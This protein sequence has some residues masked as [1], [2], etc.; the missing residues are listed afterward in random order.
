MSAKY[1]LLRRLNELVPDAPLLT[2]LEL[3]E[4]GDDRELG[5]V[6]RLW[7]AWARSLRSESVGRP[8]YVGPAYMHRVQTMDGEDIVNT[9]HELGA[10]TGLQWWSWHE[11]SLREQ[12]G[13]IQPLGGDAPIERYLSHAHTLW[14]AARREPDENKVAAIEREMRQAVPL[15]SHSVSRLTWMMCEPCLP[16]QDPHLLRQTVDRVVQLMSVGDR[17]F[18]RTFRPYDLESL[19]RMCV[20]CSDEV[21]NTHLSAIVAQLNA[22]FGT[23]GG[24][25]KNKGARPLLRWA[26]SPRADQVTA[27]RFVQQQYDEAS[28][29]SMDQDLSPERRRVL[30]DLA[31]YEAAMGNLD[32]L[33]WMVRQL[34]TTH[35][36]NL[37]VRLHDLNIAPA[38]VRELF[39]LLHRQAVAYDLDIIPP[40]EECS[41]FDEPGKLVLRTVVGLLTQDEDR[42]QELWNEESIRT[43]LQDTFTRDHG[44][45]IQA[46]HLGHILARFVARDKAGEFDWLRE[47]LSQWVKGVAEV[48]EHQPE[49]SLIIREVLLARAYLALSA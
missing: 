7:L 22:M 46:L 26:A 11:A 35:V 14:S 30:Y 37:M 21:A 23:I 34:D 32:K 24:V 36:V 27:A 10:V 41:Q 28:W 33:P 6:E 47:L 2:G 15:L 19:V 44:R 4:V 20:G 25:D 45:H 17:K 39:E 43:Y 3:S 48:A 38:Q 8:Y 31:N 9:G 40:W 16:G 29:L 49:H 18:S 5:E 13:A 1:G 42:W 12:R